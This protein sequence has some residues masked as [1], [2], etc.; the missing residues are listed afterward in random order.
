MLV[1][2]PN[3]SIAALSS[4]ATEIITSPYYYIERTLKF[5]STA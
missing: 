4:V 3:Y 2:F 5:V 1:I